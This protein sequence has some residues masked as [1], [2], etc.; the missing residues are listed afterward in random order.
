MISNGVT[1]AP[2]DEKWSLWDMRAV[3]EWHHAGPPAGA[4]YRAH[5]DPMFRVYGPMG[6]G[7]PGG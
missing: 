1:T 3:V 6:A 5:D 4:Q 7:G 2:E